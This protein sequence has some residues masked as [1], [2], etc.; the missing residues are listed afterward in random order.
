MT[1]STNN[2]GQP[3]PQPISQETINTKQYMPTSEM[4]TPTAYPKLVP[5]LSA[6]QYMSTSEMHYYKQMLSLL[7]HHPHKRTPTQNNTHLHVK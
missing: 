5:S 6:Q 7:H 1:S 2:L 3:I 4:L